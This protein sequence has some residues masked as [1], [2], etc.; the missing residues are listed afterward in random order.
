MIVGDQQ[1]LPIFDVSQ[2]DGRM[3]IEA[4]LEQGRAVV[5]I[6]MRE[7][8]STSQLLLEASFE[9]DAGATERLSIP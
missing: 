9:P 5:D 2:T 8:P 4:D 7:R 3:T 6:S 1:N